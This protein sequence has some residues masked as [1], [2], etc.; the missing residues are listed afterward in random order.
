MS[1]FP[2]Y[3]GQRKQT[4]KQTIPVLK[5]KKQNKSFSLAGLGS[6]T[7]GQGWYLCVQGQPGLCSELTRTFFQPGCQ[8]AQ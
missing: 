3:P 8:L 7:G 2:G 1:A 6:H 4:N 5:T